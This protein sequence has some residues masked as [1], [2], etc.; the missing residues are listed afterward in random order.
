[1]NEYTDARISAEIRREFPKHNR[2][3]YS[4]AKRTAETGVMLCPRAKEIAEE[5]LKKRP[6]R[7]ENRKM[8][9]R[10]YGRLPDELHRKVTAKM[11]VEHTNMQDLLVMLL[12][13]WV[14]G[15]DER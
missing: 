2:A 15:A 4:M 13:A 12:T 3:A 14:E 7:P 8:K 6:R 1:M 5:F 9:N 10:I 11:A